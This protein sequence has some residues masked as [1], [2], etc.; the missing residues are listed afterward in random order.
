VARGDRRAGVT[1]GEHGGGSG[2]RVGG[3]PHGFGVQPEGDMLRGR[4]G[5][6]SLASGAR[7]AVGGADVK[8]GEAVRRAPCGR[9]AGAHALHRPMGSN[10]CELHWFEFPKLLKIELHSKTYR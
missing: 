9:R 4:A 6:A 2:R 3:R 7:R 10:L 8:D 1:G 5:T